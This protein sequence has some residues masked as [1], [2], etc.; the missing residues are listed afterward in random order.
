MKSMILIA[1]FVCLLAISNGY[2][3]IEHKTGKDLLHVLEGGYYQ[4]GGS[5]RVY[6]FMFYNPGVGSETLQNKNREYGQAIRREVLDRYPNVYYAEVDA[7]NRD[8]VNFAEDVI[9]VNTAELIH[10][11]SVFIMTDG[12]GVTIHGP[13]AVSR[14]ARYMPAYEEKSRHF[15]PEPVVVAPV[16][17]EPVVFEGLREPVVFEP[18][19]HPVGR[20]VVNP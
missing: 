6:V 2:N 14:L 5:H 11:P 18:T 19:R 7:T 10:S 12:H 9:G 16:V 13:E 15:V 8:Y 17:R 1:M 3:M 20:V 4:D